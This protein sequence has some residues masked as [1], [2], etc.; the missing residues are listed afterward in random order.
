M[1]ANCGH[2]EYLFVSPNY[3]HCFFDDI[4][5]DFADPQLLLIAVTM[6]S[7]W[8]KLLAFKRPLRS[9]YATLRVIVV[10]KKP[11]DS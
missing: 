5:D 8:K 1:T 9:F 10:K 2:V 6:A 7:Q 4:F 11:K 3:V